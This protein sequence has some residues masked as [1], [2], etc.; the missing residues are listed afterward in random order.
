MERRDVLMTAMAGVGAL[1][2]GAAGKAVAQ[3]KAAAPVKGKR[4]DLIATASACI[5]SGEAC[6]AHCLRELGNGNKEMAKCGASVGQMLPLV[7]ATLALAA[8]DSALLPKLAVVCADACKACKEA[9]AEHKGHF[10]HGMHLE[11]KQCMEDCERCEKA[12][13]AV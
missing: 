8:Q 13:R 11:C 4:S 9:C 5:A 12:C 1:A 6:L 3:G 10:G 2:A 7:K